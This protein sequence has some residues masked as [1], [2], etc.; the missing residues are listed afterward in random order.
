MEVH[1][2]TD[3]V[4]GFVRYL[5]D[6]VLVLAP[7]VQVFQ[8]VVDGGFLG[9]VFLAQENHRTGVAQGLVV[10]LRGVLEDFLEGAGAARGIDDAPLW[11]GD[12]VVLPDA[13]VEKLGDLRGERRGGLVAVEPGRDAQ[14]MKLRVVRV[15]FHHFE[16]VRQPARV[17]EGGGDADRGERVFHLRFAAAGEPGAQMDGFHGSR[18]AAADHQF[19][20]LGEP[21]ADLDD[22]AVVRVGALDGMAAHDG[23]DVL[24]VVVLDELF[25]GVADGMVVQDTA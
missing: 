10:V 3:D 18:S 7:L 5:Q 17:A 22:L 14:A 21:L 6:E 2:E 1:Q 24:L 8:Q 4:F 25:Q 23:D 15:F 12:D 16:S 11:N 13:V 9:I 19:A 20:N